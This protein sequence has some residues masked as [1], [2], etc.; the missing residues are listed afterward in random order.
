MASCC[1]EQKNIGIGWFV[2]AW[3]AQDESVVGPHGFDIGTAGGANAT[4]YRHRPGS[5]NAAAKG[6]EDADAPVA[7]FVAAALDD[8]VAIIG[9]SDGY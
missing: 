8:D 4:G 7:E 1:V 2:S 3:E 9:H 6:S 5:V